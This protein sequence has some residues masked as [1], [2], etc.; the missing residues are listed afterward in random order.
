MELKGTP[1]RADQWNARWKV[2]SLKLLLFPERTDDHFGIC[3]FEV[4]KIVVGKNLG[5]DKTE[6]TLWQ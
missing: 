3:D 4:Y 5:T 2:E 6:G 1:R